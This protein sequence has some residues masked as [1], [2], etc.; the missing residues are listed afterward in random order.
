[1]LFLF[2]LGMKNGM[3]RTQIIIVGFEN[4]YVDELVMLVYLI[5]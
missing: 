1:M 5:S 4:S 3:E 2:D